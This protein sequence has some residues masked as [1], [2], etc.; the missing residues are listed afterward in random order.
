MGRVIRQP[1][2]A[3]SMLFPLTRLTAASPARGEGPTYPKPQHGP[4]PSFDSRHTRCY[5]DSSLAQGTVHVRHRH[6]RTR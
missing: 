3:C 6:R 1:G 2:A 4:F 5:P